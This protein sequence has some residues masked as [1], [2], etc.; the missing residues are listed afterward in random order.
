MT[1]GTSAAT[2]LWAAFTALVNQQATNS[3]HAP[4]GFLNPALYAIAVS[5]TNYA[6]C[7]NDITT[8]NNTWSGSPNLFYAVTNYDLCTGLGT[9]SG[10][11]LINALLTVPTN[12][13]NFQVS[14]PLPPYGTNLAAI[15][16]GS[17]NGEWSLFV[18]DA[19][20]VNSGLIANGW[21]INLTLGSPVGAE[22]DLGL[23]LNA[24][25]TTVT[26][27]NNL[28][29]FLTITNFGGMSTA[30]NVLVFDSLQD[31]VT[32]LSSNVSV[33]S[34]TRSGDAVSWDVGNLLTNAGGALSLTVR[35]ATTQESIFNS[36]FASSSTPDPNPSD[37]SVSITVNAVTPVA[38]LLS[39]NAVGA[40]GA[41]ILTASDLTG[42]T[43]IQASTNLVN[44]TTIFTTNSTAAFTFTDPNKTNF[45]HRFYR[46]LTGQ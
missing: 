30:T 32:L 8:G 27:G 1:A 22:A 6:A 2:P 10:T 42:S 16:G 36:A 23:T 33:G 3:S 4:V 14:P 12:I 43:S 31:D 26:P 13:Y 34:V 9:P 35:T 20:T 28:T 24:S 21:V 17:P 39:A 41:F 25:S 15:N 38:P 44:W 7:F 18:Q 29:Y 5:P 46:V 11:N 40:S 37:G 19:G 45:S